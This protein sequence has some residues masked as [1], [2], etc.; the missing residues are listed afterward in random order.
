M[1]FSVDAF[2]VVS[3]LGTRPHAR[4]VMQSPPD[5]PFY[6]VVIDLTPIEGPMPAESLGPYDTAADAAAHLAE[7]PDLPVR[8]PTPEGSMP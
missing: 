7:L 1:P 8:S 6:A 2:R 3:D 5:G 4:C